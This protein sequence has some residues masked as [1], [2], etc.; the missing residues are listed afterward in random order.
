[1]S[2]V[3][4]IEDISFL[5][6]SVA[7]LGFLLPIVPRVKASSI[8]TEM[9]SSLRKCSSS[10]K[11]VIGY[12][13]LRVPIDFTTLRLISGFMSW[14]RVER[15]PSALSGWYLLTSSK[16]EKA[17]DLTGPIGFLTISSMNFITLLDCFSLKL[18]RKIA[19]FS[20]VVGLLD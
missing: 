4:F 11:S 20:C 5:Y 17:D 7:C 9:S 1:M 3:D 18:P 8:F 12:D 15:I 10:L 6:I 16:E 19:I 13:S 14:D 2:S